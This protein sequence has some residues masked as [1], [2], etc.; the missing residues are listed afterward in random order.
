MTLKAAPSKEAVVRY[1]NG[2]EGAG[3]ELVK[4]FVE[5]TGLIAVGI[6]LLGDRNNFMRNSLSASLAIE[7]YL[8]WYYSQQMKENN[9]TH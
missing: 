5:R 8:L 1:L 9:T 3:F 4:T 7:L 2:E 6:Y